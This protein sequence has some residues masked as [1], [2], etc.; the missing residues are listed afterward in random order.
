MDWFTSLLSFFAALD[1]T[2]IQGVDADR[3]HLQ[4]IVNTIL[5]IAG[6]VAALIIVVAG[7]RYIVSQ[8]QPNETATARNAILYA[9]IG[10]IVII[11]AFAIVNFV[12]S[13]I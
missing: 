6:A 12:V 5:A 11:A 8:G 1:L 7:F 4:A 13:G 3:P 10:L 2:P 9:S